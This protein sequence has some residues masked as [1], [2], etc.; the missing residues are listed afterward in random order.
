MERITIRAFRAIDE[1]K[2]C[3]TYLAEHERVLSDIGVLSAFPADASWT[4]DPST[5]VVVAF[6]K[7]LG[8]VAGVRL[9]TT[10]TDHVLPIEHYLYPLDRKIRGS[11]ALLQPHGNAEM[12]GLWNAHRFAGRGVPFLLISAATAISNQ[13]PLNSLVC[14]AAEY[15]VPKCVEIGFRIM[16]DIGEKGAFQFPVPSIRS[17][18]MVLSDIRVLSAVK[19]DLRQRMLSLRICPDQCRKEL[20]KHTAL[21]VRYDLLLDPLREEFKQIARERKRYAA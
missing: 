2:L 11:L 21:D 15:M 7:E 4:R 20:P 1:P 10:G 17:Y 6:H 5:I 9:Q 13:L 16:E 8:M 3:E 18:P 12:C 14:L 19:S